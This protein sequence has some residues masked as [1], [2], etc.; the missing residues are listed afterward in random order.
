MALLARAAGLTLLTLPLLSFACGSSGGGAPSTTTSSSSSSS[1][2][3]GGGSTTIACT[4][5][6]AKLAM[7]GTW[8]AYARLSIT[9]QGL[10]GGAI[11]IC[12]ADQVGESTLLLL[13]TVDTDAADPSKLKNIT[14]TLC[15]L[16]LPVVTALAGDC[17]KDA[18]NLVSTQIIAP[19]ALID[20]LPD[21]KT[22]PVGG[23]LASLTPGAAATLDR[24]T[25]TVG[26]AKP[27]P[28]MPTWNISSNPCSSVDI[29]RSMTCEA[30]C[31]S[32]CAS[33]IDGDADG[34]PGVT[35]EVCGVTPD[36][37]KAGVKCNAASP[38]DPGTVL[39]GRAFLDIQ[40]DP[41]VTGAAK[42]SC[43]IVG[44]VD[45]KVLYNIVGADVYLGGAQIGVDSA[46]K[47]LPTFQVDPTTSK[48]RMIRVDGKYGSP[49]WK[50]DPAQVKTSCKTIITHVNDF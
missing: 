6:P 49:D 50:L 5:Q 16:E 47:S 26:S 32:D 33:M 29:G 1:G 37:T 11:T 19:A 22:T 39:Q 7:A 38:S 46:I 18:P 12:P 31:V 24:F 44:N 35:A 2:A 10:P 41:L 28:N 30:I 45:T 20:S 43:E 8:A 21:I 17:M 27:D 15:S 13:M 14:A 4:G 40:V 9:L 25:V 23:S 3:G 42:S 48:V 34:F 36:D